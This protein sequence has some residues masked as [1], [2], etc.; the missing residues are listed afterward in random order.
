MA[1]I[2]KVSEKFDRLFAYVCTFK[3]IFKVTPM[4]SPFIEKSMARATDNIEYTVLQ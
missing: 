4:H 3:H 2:L 1:T